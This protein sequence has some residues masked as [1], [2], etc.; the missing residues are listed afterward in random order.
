MWYVYRMKYVVDL[1]DLRLADIDRVGGKSASLGEMLQELTELG[2]NIPGGFAVTVDAYRELDQVTFA[3]KIS[4][5]YQFTSQQ[6]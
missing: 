6:K 4:T 2:V 5:P 3:K 1:N